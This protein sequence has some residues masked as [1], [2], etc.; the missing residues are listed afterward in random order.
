M[1]S[2][3]RFTMT[4]IEKEKDFT[5]NEQSDCPNGENV[6]AHRKRNKRNYQ[7]FIL[8]K[9]NTIFIIMYRKAKIYLFKYKTK[10]NF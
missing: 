10:P 2:Q 7:F 8:P 9:R 1:T 5:S 4:Q 3:T 6:P